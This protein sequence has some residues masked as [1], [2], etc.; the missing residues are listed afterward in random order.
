MKG[1]SGALAAVAMLVLTSCASIPSSSQVHKLPANQP[2]N[3]TQFVRVIARPPALNAKPLAIVKGFLDAC[4]DTSGDFS[5]ARKYLLAQTSTRWRPDS[6][7]TTYDASTLDITK[8]GVDFHISGA[9]TGYIDIFQHYTAVVSPKPLDY[10]MSLVR[11]SKDQWRIKSL[12]NG[13]IAPLA[14]VQRRIKGFPVYFFDKIN[15]HL[16]PDYVVVP[17]GSSGTATAL[18]QSLLAGPRATLVSFLN[19]SIPAGTRLNYGSVPVSKGIATVDLALNE[20]SLDPQAFYRMVSQIVWTLDRIDTVRK[21]R[22]LFSGRTYAKSELPPVIS[23]RKVSRFSPQFPNR[24]PAL[25]MA[26]AK[27]IYSI[28]ADQQRIVTTLPIDTSSSTA[29]FSASPFSGDLAIVGGSGKNLYVK[30]A[31]ENSFRQVFAGEFLS[32]PSWSRSGHVFVADYGHWI[33]AISMQGDISFLRVD[34][35]VFGGAT[36]VSRVAIAP[37]GVQIAL[38]FGT[39]EASSLA[40][41]ILVPDGEHTRVVGITPVA[42]GLKTVRDIEWIDEVHVAILSSTPANTSELR[43]ISLADGATELIN[44]PF[45]SRAMSFSA[46]GRLVVSA[47][48]NSESQILERHQG[49]WLEQSKGNLASFSAK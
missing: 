34:Q 12:P 46:H 36:D 21:V 40:T 4:A 45:E 24:T 6:Q 43:N 32:K 8:V 26:K 47:V 27:T 10:R 33:A 29:S 2:S 22:L 41:G 19:S 23:V 18:M 16:V 17:R 7:I 30:T 25:L 48:R 49:A 3:D 13:V 1:R 42:T 11:D 14:D 28:A 31:A 20:Y 5:V 15:S 37:D 39:P 44:I 38:L 35:S 9:V